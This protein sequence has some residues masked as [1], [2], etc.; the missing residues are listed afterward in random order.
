MKEDIKQAFEAITAVTEQYRGTKQEHIL[1][2]QYLELIKKEI[3]KCS[4]KNPVTAEDII[5]P[6]VSA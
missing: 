2:H 5:K 3:S 4:C 1:I 6:D